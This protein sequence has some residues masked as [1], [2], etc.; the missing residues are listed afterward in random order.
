M[1]KNIEEQADKIIKFN[2]KM[3][4]AAGD[5]WA[6]YPQIEELD[7][8]KFKTFKKYL[9]KHKTHHLYGI[10]HSDWVKMWNEIYEKFMPVWKIIKYDWGNYRQNLNPSFKKVLG[11]MFYWY[12][13]LIERFFEERKEEK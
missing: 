8:F 4:R 13:P 7:K 12:K 9:R 5:V 3:K 1:N 6:L 11:Y 10:P 2:E